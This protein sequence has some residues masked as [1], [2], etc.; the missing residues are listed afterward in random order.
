LFFAACG[1][2]AP[3]LAET[4]QPVEKGPPVIET[5]NAEQRVYLYNDRLEPSPKGEGPALDIS[6]SLLDITG[7]TVLQKNIQ[8]IFY[9]GLS[10][11]DY[12]TKLTNSLSTEYRAQK[13]DEQGGASRE[14]MNWFYREVIALIAETPGALVISLD[15]ESYTGGAHGVTKRDYFVF[16]LNNGNKLLLTDILEADAMPSLQKLAE[17]ELR[18]ALGVSPRLPLTEKGFFSDTLDTL[19]DFYINSRGIGIQWDPYEIAPYAMGAMEILIS[20]QLVEGMLNPLGL[21]LIK[22]FF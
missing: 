1:T 4:A 7:F 15:R 22:D 17:G 16:D 12:V 5:F 9:E 6:L 14:S 20:T 11:A 21:S 3:T 10:T 8:D 2:N 18:K 19:S 13:A